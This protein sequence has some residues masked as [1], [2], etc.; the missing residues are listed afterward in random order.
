MEGRE[1]ERYWALSCLKYLGV[2]KGV[3]GRRDTSSLNGGRERGASGHGGG[4]GRMG[5]Q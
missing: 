5:A 1:Q 2:E 4:S 3:I